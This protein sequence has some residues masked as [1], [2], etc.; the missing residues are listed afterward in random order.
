MTA[1]NVLSVMSITVCKRT[2]G[3]GVISRGVC[4]CMMSL[5]LWLHVP[6]FLL[7]EGVSS[8][9]LMFLL[10][11]SVQGGL[12]PG[13]ASLCRRGVSDLQ[14]G[15]YPGG[16]SLSWR[17][18][19]VQGVF[20]GRPYGI[21]KTDSAHPTRMLSCFFLHLLLINSDQHIK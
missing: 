12:C 16:G 21:R 15:L 11:V 4:L 8:H 2:L 6:M 7:G 20:V 9:G 13:G 10:E 14:G 5:P 19:S 1:C 18:V 3:Q 17:G